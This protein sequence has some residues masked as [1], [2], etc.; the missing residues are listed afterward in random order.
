MKAQTMYENIANSLIVS[1]LGHKACVT[2]CLSAQNEKKADISTNQLI[3]SNV[4]VNKSEGLFLNGTVVKK[5]INKEAVLEHLNMAQKCVNEKFRQ[6]VEASNL[7]ADAYAWFTSKKSEA[8]RTKYAIKW[9]KEEFGQKAFGLSK[10]QFYKKD[11]LGKTALEVVEGFITADITVRMNGLKHSLSIEACNKFT[12]QYVV[13]DVTKMTKKEAKKCISDAIAKYVEDAKNGKLSK[14][15]AKGKSDAKD[16]AK[17]SKNR[18]TVSMSK[19]GGDK[20]MSLNIDKD[21]KLQAMTPNVDKK[22]AT[23]LI[24]DLAKAFKD[25]GI[26][27]DGKVPSEVKAILETV[28]L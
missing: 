23:K 2:S 13:K 4:T 12:N 11:A 22:M 10:A 14:A 16:K 3:M 1:K 18:I 15:K 20:G 26:F 6:E 5:A 19:Y 7:I 21:G 25:A 17:G 27:A 9:T 8:Q 28:K 24:T